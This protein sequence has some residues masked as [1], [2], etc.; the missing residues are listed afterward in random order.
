MNTNFVTDINKK[1]SHAKMHSAHSKCPHAYAL[2][3]TPVRQ[4]RQQNTTHTNTPTYNPTHTYVRA[5]CMR[6]DMG[7]RGV[8]KGETLCMSDS[9]GVHLIK[10]TPYLQ[11]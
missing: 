1:C 4:S 6:V 10:K 11:Q 3:T 8:C 5:W 2:T 9:K 7:E